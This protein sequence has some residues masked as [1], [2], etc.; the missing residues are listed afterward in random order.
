MSMDARLLL[1]AKCLAVGMGVVVLGGLVWIIVFARRLRNAANAPLSVKSA[2]PAP[3]PTEKIP[4]CD[5][6]RREALRCFH[7]SVCGLDCSLQPILSRLPE[8]FAGEWSAA[9]V[10]HCLCLSGLRQSP[11]AAE[12]LSP[13]RCGDWETWAKKKGLFLSRTDAA[14]TLR[15]GDLVLYAEPSG[16]MG[17]VLETD[18]ENNRLTAAEGDVGDVSAVVS[19]PIDGRIRGRIRLSE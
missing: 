11:D 2:A 10:Y 4:L 17:V 3:A 18:E 7:G 1:F 6:A 5:V 19:R 12:G 9:F 8:P 16:H 14:F 15:P 13:A